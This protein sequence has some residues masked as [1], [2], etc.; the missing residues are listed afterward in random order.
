MPYL[1]LSLAVIAEVIGTSAL[2][3]SA[4]FTLWRP[5]ALM[6]VSYALSMYC[7]ALALKNIPLG[8]AYAIWAGA[9]I[10]LL[11]LVG[12]VVFKQYPDGPALLG[13][14]MICAGVIIIRLFS[15]MSL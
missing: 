15:K 5:G 14:A 7:F 13:I 9:G 10:A 12:I 3:A 8:V 1:Y 4:G 6:I 2:K 11:L